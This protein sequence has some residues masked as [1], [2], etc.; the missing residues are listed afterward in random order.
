VAL[1]RFLGSN[2]DQRDPAYKHQAAQERRDRDDLLG[3]GRGLDGA[4][5]DNFLAAC[6]A[7]ALMS[8]S[9]DAEK[10]KSDPNKRYRFAVHKVLLPLSF[11]AETAKETCVP[12]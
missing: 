6:A 2:R 11:E 5:V 8:K 9:H 7:A 3:V 4:N 1:R 10:D 12:E